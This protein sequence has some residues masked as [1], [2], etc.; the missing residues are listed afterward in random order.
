MNRKKNFKSQQA[1][2]FFKEEIDL[3]LHKKNL[4]KVSTKAQ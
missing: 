4:T 1:D 2:V 3:N